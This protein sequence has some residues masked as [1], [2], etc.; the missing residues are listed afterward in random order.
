[1]RFRGRLLT[2][3]LCGLSLSCGCSR[4]HRRHVR[5]NPGAG[6]SPP[7]V[8][9]KLR[10]EALRLGVAPVLSPRATARSYEGLARFL[11]RRLGL[12]GELVLTSTYAEM[13]QALR[14]RECDLAFVC[15]YSYVKG[16]REFGLRA[17]AV[18]RINGRTIHRSYLIVPADSRAA[19]LADLRGKRF[20]F[21]EPESMTGRL[22]P[23]YWLRTEQ[24][25]SPARFFGSHLYTYGHDNSLWAVATKRVEGAAV[26]SLV[27]DHML[28]REASLR[29]RLKVIR[30]SPPLGMPPVVVRP[31]LERQKARRLEQVLLTMH[32]SEQGRELLADLMVDRFVRPNEENYEPTREVAT[33]VGWP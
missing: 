33:K 12:P 25:E 4:S 14:R 23:L 27:Y 6:A 11:G 8:V 17:L 7:A 10:Q 1:M 16:R 9:A 2:V 21:T 32:E 22:V 5:L 15:C 19:R 29:E 28:L 13:N 3:L 24:G 31:G 26:D 18:P 30:T 20:A